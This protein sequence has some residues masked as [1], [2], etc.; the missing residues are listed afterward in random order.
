MAL[1]AEG[2]RCYPIPVLKGIT[3]GG[4]YINIYPTIVHWV[5]KL[6]RVHEHFMVLV[7]CIYGLLMDLHNYITQKLLM[8]LLK[9]N[10]PY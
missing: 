4:F 5:V 1:T 2:L 7:S 6:H 3:H 9:K 8:K 10:N